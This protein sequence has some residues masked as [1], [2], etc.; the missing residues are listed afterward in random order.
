MN[1][2]D[3][4]GCKDK[5]TVIKGRSQVE[6]R[7]L[8]LNSF[9]IVYIDGSH[10]AK[11]VLADA[12]LSWELLKTGGIMIFDDYKWKGWEGHKL[13]AELRPEIAIDSFISIFKNDIEIIHKDYQV[14]L[15]KL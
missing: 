15:K 3:S 14:I 2:L 11:N 12:I 6:L 13:T 8:P 10:K 1:N 4:S 5:V 9:D 7:Y